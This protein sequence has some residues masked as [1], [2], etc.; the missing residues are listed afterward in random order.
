MKT[1]KFKN[2]NKIKLHKTVNYKG[3]MVYIRQIREIFE[4][5]IVFD[6]QIRTAY[7]VFTPEKGKKKLTKA[8]QARA[9]GFAFGLAVT[10]V[11]KFLENSGKIKED[12]PK[13]KEIK[14]T[15]KVE[16]TVH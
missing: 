13:P 12:D 14:I 5:L 10:A 15:K 9:V 4:W 3:C 1:P 8:Q 11:D 6:E 2:I 16:R 7:V